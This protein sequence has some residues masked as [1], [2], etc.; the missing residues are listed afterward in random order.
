MKARRMSDQFFLLLLILC[1]AKL[2]LWVVKTLW[3]VGKAIF[4]TNE[5]LP[6]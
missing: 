3:R 2:I 1:G 4:T 5:K 6:S